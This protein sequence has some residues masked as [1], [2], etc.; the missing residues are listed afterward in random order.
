MITITQPNY[1]ECYINNT[2]IPGDIIFNN[3]LFHN[4]ICNFNDNTLTLLESKTI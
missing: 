2:L 3:K 4:D 1:K